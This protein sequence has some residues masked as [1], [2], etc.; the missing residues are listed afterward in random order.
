MVIMEFALA[1]PAGSVA[2]QNEENA[3]DVVAR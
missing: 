2:H 1:D 3:I